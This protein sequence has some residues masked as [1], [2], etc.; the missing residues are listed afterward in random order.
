VCDRYSECGADADG[1]GVD[2]GRMK[3]ARREYGVGVHGCVGCDFEEGLDG[4]YCL[5]SSEAAMDHAS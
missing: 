1:Y 4:G 2:L 5:Y 3:V